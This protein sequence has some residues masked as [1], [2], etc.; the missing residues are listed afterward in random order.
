MAGE[1]VGGRRREG[2]LDSAVPISGAN[3]TVMTLCYHPGKQSAAPA[4]T[5]LLRSDGLTRGKNEPF[6]LLKKLLRTQTLV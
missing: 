5:H 2:D 6:L 3:C 1:R 4:D